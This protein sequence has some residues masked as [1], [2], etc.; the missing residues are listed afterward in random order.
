LIKDLLAIDKNES[1]ANSMGNTKVKIKQAHLK[2]CS[3][4][5][6]LCCWI[7]A[8]II[9]IVSDITISLAWTLLLLH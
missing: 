9:R 8:S 4:K 2:S 6:L 3:P 1:F 7:Y 5:A